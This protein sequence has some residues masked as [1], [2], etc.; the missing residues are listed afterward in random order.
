MILPDNF[1]FLT[2]AYQKSLPG[3]RTGNETGSET[4]SGCS[5]KNI[6]VLYWAVKRHRL[7]L[8]IAILG[9]VYF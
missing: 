1:A 9:C 8:V 4:G 2:D 7:E 5:E 3:K 6:K